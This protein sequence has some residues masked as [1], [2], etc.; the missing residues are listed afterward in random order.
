MGRAVLLTT[1]ACLALASSFWAPGASG[2]HEKQYHQ[3]LTG[4]SPQYHEPSSRQLAPAWSSARREGSRANAC[5]IERHW[6]SP[7]YARHIDASVIS[8]L[9]YCH[10]GS[11]H[12]TTN[13]TYHFVDRTVISVRSRASISTGISSSFR[14]SSRSIEPS[15]K[16][17]DSVAVRRE[18]RL[19]LE[20]GLLLGAV[21]MAFLGVWFWATRLRRRP[22]S[23][24]S[25]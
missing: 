11:A 15:N 23:A 1:S 18:P 25:A 22:R 21:Y 7:K 17:E 16:S 9:I 13:M 8:P 24:T 5:A 4:L 12:V 20:I 2:A 19:M 3:A 6:Y 10:S 14:R